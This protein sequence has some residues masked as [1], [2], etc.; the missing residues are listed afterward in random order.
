MRRARFALACLP[1]LSALL[2][3]QTFEEKVRVE[4]V[5][6]E[7]LA[8]D[9]QSRP[10]RDLRPDEVRVR[11]DGRSTTIEGLEAP[12]SAQASS[13]LSLPPT[14]PDS[15]RATP[16]PVERAKTPPPTPRPRYL[17]AILADETSSEQSN[18]QAVYA[19]LFRFLEGGLPPGVEAQLMRFDG[20]LRVECPWTS[21]GG[22]LRRVAAA[23]ARRPVASR[24]GA[25]GALS[26]NPEQGAFNMQLEAMEAEVHIRTSLAGLFDALRTFPDTPGRKALY[27]VSDGAPFLAPSEVAKDLIASSTSSVDGS[28]PNA[29]YRAA[30]E[31]QRDSDLLLDSLAWNRTHSASLLTD[32]AR[33]ALVRGVEIHPVR[34]APQDLS[35]RVRTDRSFSARATARG[36][37]PLDAR[38][39][40]NAATPPTTDIAAGQSMEAVAETTGGEAVLS[41]RSF[42]DGLKQEVENRDAA[43]VISFRD[44]FAGDHRF[45]KVEITSTRGG[46]RLRY[47]R[48]YRVL[49]VAESLLESA[50]NR[51]YVAS[52]ANPLGVRLR[53]D[54]PGME[55]GR[56]R[57]DITVAYPA[58]PRA[59]GG[60][61][62]GGAVRVVAFCA[63]RDGALRHFDLGG[64]AESAVFGGV[65]W[66][67]RAGGIALPP[68]AYRWS[69]AIRDEETGITS[70]LTFDRVLP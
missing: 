54:S 16:V 15:P 5:R 60:T 61:A 49:D 62:E 31:A 68:G 2:F 40:R 10:I 26:G 13:P 12:Q 52:D 19:E 22:R 20:H 33:L 69:F 3:A 7:V 43:Y 50:V 17:M 48:G 56:V 58:P 25:P 18:R 27:F 21:D 30:I 42:E 9:A 55:K 23:M 1:A 4:L 64:A 8:T 59:G 46:A 65:S 28:D 34:A 63:V 44:P 29:A 41:R 35:G 51:L 39:L 45:H 57:A 70:Y 32:V 67:T 53:I 11:V 38:S 37:A 36:G 66:R 14:V 24:V 47:R 6:I